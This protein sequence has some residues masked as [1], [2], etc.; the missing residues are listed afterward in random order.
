MD[1]A[2][3]RWAGAAKVEYCWDA[4]GGIRNGPRSTS[5][6]RPHTNKGGGRVGRRLPSAFFNC[7]APSKKGALFGL[8][9]RGGA[10]MTATIEEMDW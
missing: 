1:P 5:A 9:G 10:P 3:H 2:I 7:L 8:T 6:W 4:R